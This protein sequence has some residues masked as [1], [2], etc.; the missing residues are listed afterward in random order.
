[1]FFGHIDTENIWFTAF[2]IE[3]KSNPCPREEKAHK[4]DDNE[5]RIAA[6][7]L[8][9]AVVYRWFWNGPKNL[10]L[11]RIQGEMLANVEANKVQSMLWL[12]S[13]SPASRTTKTVAVSP[14][15]R[16]VELMLNG[17]PHVLNG[18]LR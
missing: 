9:G 7:S 10:N 13:Y 3:N 4:R 11:P 12:T 1:M 6:R 15:H 5:V 18:D 14:H 17:L 8:V 2:Y 16:L